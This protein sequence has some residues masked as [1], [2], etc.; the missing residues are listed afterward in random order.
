MEISQEDFWLKDDQIMKKEELPGNFIEQGTSLYEV[1]RVIRGVP[2][3]FEH[4]MDRLNR[5]ARLT[6]LQI[7]VDTETIKGRLHN[8]ISI[9]QVDA[10]NIKIVLNYPHKKEPATSY[11]YFTEAHY[12][13]STDYQKGV[14]TVAVNIERPNPNAKVDRAEYR[15]IIDSAKEKT[16]SY[17]ALLVDHNGYV[18]EGGRSNLFMIKG[19]LVLTAPGDKVLKGINR[20]MVFTACQNIG[21]PLVEKEVSYTEM[22]AMDAIFISGTSPHVLPVSQVDDKHFDSATNPILRSIMAEFD[23]IVEEYIETNGSV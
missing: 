11:T 2:I 15:Q 10:G 5:T 13:S 12:P 22:L 3:F 23:K 16:N 20:Q 4:H 17:E 7:P 6:G 14:K 8:L 1:I 9:N 21:Q 19:D 18:T